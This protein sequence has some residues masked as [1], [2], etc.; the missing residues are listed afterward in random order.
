VKKPRQKST[1][2]GKQL[3]IA[4]R[5]GATTLAVPRRFDEVLA[6]IEAAQRR[7]YQAVNAELVSLYWQLGKYISRKISSAEWGDGVVDELAT[8]IARQYPG[9]RGYTRRNLFRMRQFFD[10]YQADAIV[11]PLVT[12]LPWTHHLILLSQTK[13]PGRRR[14]P[15]MTLPPL[16]SSFLVIAIAAAG[17]HLMALAAAAFVAPGMATAT[18]ATSSDCNA[19]AA[20]RGPRYGKWT[21]ATADESSCCHAMSVPIDP[22]ARAVASIGVAPYPMRQ[23]TFAAPW[24]AGPG[25]WSP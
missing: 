17:V 15:R 12:Q 6:L 11:S 23:I 9:M 21:V 10:A 2:A 20:P 1:K 3:V 13:H 22:R 18:G 8:T 14:S 25:G 4:A 5:R 19:L 24:R 7:A 16:P